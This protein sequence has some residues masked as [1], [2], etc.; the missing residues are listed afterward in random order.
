[1]SSYYADERFDAATGWS[2]DITEG[3]HTSSA[4]DEMKNNLAGQITGTGLEIGTGIATDAATTPLLALGPWGWIGYG[5]TNFLSG[6]SSNIAAQR[7]RGES[8]ISWG[9]VLSSGAID[10]IPFLGVKAK[11]AK[12]VAN[13]ALQ[14]G[15]KTVAQQ[16]GAVGI[17]EQRWLTPTEAGVSFGS[18]TL[19]GGTIK[20]APEIVGSLSKQVANPFEIPGFVK[21]IGTGFGDGDEIVRGKKVNDAWRIQ[22]DSA[23][24]AALEGFPVMTN[25]GKVNSKFNPYL[26]RNERINYG[27]RELNVELPTAEELK[28]RAKIGPTW[29]SVDSKTVA[30]S[31]TRDWSKYERDEAAYFLEQR[32]PRDKE[33]NELGDVIKSELKTL[34]PDI[35]LSSWRRHHTNPLKQGAQLLNGLKPQYRKE[36]VQIM[37]R[38]GLYAGHDPK[39]LKV[40]PHKVHVQIHNFI[41]KY[42]GKDTVATLERKWLKPGQKIQDVPWPDREKIIKDY[43]KIVKESNQKV[44]DMMT[45]I[46][47]NKT[48]GPNVL[49]EVLAELNSKVDAE[50][51]GL[52]DLLKQ[53]KNELNLQEISG[54]V[55][56]INLQ[57]LADQ[58]TDN[59]SIK[60]QLMRDAASGN[61]TRRQLKRKYPGL[62]VKQ[63][64]LF[65]K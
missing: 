59:P 65:D 25:S 27:H 36:A 7:L 19:L 42:I 22:M 3:L 31:E 26:T 49:P 20:A 5:V 62:S 2:A 55:P 29:Q 17:D 41:N 6:A 63:L 30:G 50:D 34:Y 11:G 18:G 16:Q 14:S 61:F 1:M 37:F 33:F 23:R 53:I 43:A 52:D 44:Y 12:G 54:T 8:E 60:E 28:R 10:I 58:Y 45:A 47:V 51:V 4:Q 64:D 9:E 48:Q 32:W 35:P 13:I 57:K 38:E 56:K 21:G 40:I 46:A 24:E 15:A 39:Q